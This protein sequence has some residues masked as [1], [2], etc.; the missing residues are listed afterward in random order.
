MCVIEEPKSSPYKATFGTTVLGKAVL[1]KKTLHRDIE[2]ALITKLKPRDN[3]IYNEDSDLSQRHSPLLS[4][5]ELFNGVFSSHDC[6][7]NLS[8]Y[9][10]FSELVKLGNELFEKYFKEHGKYPF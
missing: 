9:K 1:G 7:K 3:V 10:E 2:Q 5:Q 8:N 4:P 6:V